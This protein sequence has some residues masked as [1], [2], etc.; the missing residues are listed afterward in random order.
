[1]PLPTYRALFEL[2]PH[3]LLVADPDGIVVEANPAVGVL[4]GYRVDDLVGVRLRDLAADPRAADLLRLRVE[5]DGEWRG[6]LDVLR[7]DGASVPVD[8]VVRLAVLEGR[9]ALVAWLHDAS[10]RRQQQ[11]IQREFVSMVGHELRNP[12]SSLKGYAQLMERR[13]VYSQDGI[14]TI[15]RQTDRLSRMVG[16]L[17]DAARIEAGQL[18]LRRTEVDLVARVAAVVE[19]ARESTGEQAPRL[20]APGRPIVGLW[21]RERVEQVVANLLGNALK[22]GGDGPVVVRVEDRGDDA[23]VSVA[24]RGPG[25]DAESL[26]RLFERFFRAP[27]AVASSAKGM[28]IGLYVCRGLVEAHGGRI[29]AESAPGQGS[30]FSF[31]LPKA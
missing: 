5:Q 31:T 11:R 7:R 8:A 25:I 4:L 19:A 9:P 3:P 12:L 15:V 26:P 20:D 27:D 2:D 14:R 29:W 28:G 6:E 1:M 13:G 21:D 24:D 17:A 10:E 30:T 22:Y 23:C 16:C 18:E